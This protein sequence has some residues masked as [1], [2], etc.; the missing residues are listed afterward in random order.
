M[1][2]GITMTPEYLAS[3]TMPMVSNTPLFLSLLASGC[4]KTTPSSACC[5]PIHGCTWVE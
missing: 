1:M 2:L 4:S 3:S 5:G